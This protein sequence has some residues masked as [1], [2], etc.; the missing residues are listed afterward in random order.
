L[1]KIR[2]D[3]AAKVLALTIVVMLGTATPGDAKCPFARYRFSFQIVEEAT[4]A[5]VAG[6][7][8]AVLAN[9]SDR[10]LARPDA[11]AVPAETGTDGVFAAEY[12]F[13]TY[14]SLSFFGAHRCN[15]RIKTLTI[16]VRHP[17][18]RERRVALNA[19]ELKT[20]PGPDFLTFDAILP[21]IRI[22]PDQP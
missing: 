22:S 17:R 9:A 7:R 19:K 2:A 14:T 12:R 8:I 20:R 3:F 21:T 13:G 16:V 10:E 6:A 1:K 15:E 4:G 11:A 5:P 18:Y